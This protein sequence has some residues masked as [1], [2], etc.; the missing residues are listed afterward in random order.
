[1]LSCQFLLIISDDN[2]GEPWR[3]NAS[4]VDENLTE[5]T[6]S[7]NSQFYLASF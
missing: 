7:I 4:D 6:G 5:N 2:A 3:R 1:M